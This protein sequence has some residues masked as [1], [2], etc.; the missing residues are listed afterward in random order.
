MKIGVI[1][2][3][4]IGGSMAIDLKKRRFATEVFGCDNNQLHAQTALQMGIVDKIL[5]IEDLIQQSELIIIAIPVDAANKLIPEL[6]NKVTTQT[7]CDVCS[8]KGKMV[9]LIKY[10]PKRTNYVASHPMAGT[11][12]SGPWAAIS[13][14]FD[15]KAAILC[16]VTENEPKHVEKVEAMYHAL[17]MRILYM[18]AHQQDVHCAYVSHISHI[19]SFALASTVLDKE[20][21]EK[22]IFDLASG[23]FDS[24]VRLAKSSAEMWA[25]IFVNNKENI[26]TVLDTYIQKLEEF[27]EAIADS[28]REKIFEIIENSNKI[29]KTLK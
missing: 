3:G 16:N 11:E 22:H 20:K 15:S 21:N 12:Y 27:K 14:L 23:G 19:T 26:L 24:T 7:V 17:N 13:N 2:L 18:D 10:H 8:T 9:D 5:G 29:K 1:G 4:L 25:P 28:D 6:L